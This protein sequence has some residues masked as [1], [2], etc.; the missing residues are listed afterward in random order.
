MVTLL[1]VGAVLSTVT[2]LLEVSESPLLS[3]TVISQTMTSDGEETVA[4][5]CKES[6]V[7]EYT[8]PVVLLVQAYWTLSASP[9]ASVAL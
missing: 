4:S 1:S 6:L 3:V 2:E 9:S 5:S 8:L 7:E